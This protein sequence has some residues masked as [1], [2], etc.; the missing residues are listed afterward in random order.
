MRRHQT[1]RT[2]PFRQ[3]DAVKRSPPRSMSPYPIVSLE[4]D[5]D[6]HF[7]VRVAHDRNT[8]TEFGPWTDWTRAHR[9]FRNIADRARGRG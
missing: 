4:T 2:A 1:R 7:I 3:R 8:V 6:D 9:E 5:D